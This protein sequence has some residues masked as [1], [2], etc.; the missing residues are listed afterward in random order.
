MSNNF[1]E[2]SQHHPNLFNTLTPL[3][4]KSN[5]SED[6]PRHGEND[7]KIYNFLQI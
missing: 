7:I 3:H 5:I 4:I 1:K 6:K 2:T